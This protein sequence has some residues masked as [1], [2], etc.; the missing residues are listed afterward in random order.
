MGPDGEKEGVAFFLDKYLAAFPEKQRNALKK[1]AALHKKYRRKG[2][3]SADFTPESYVIHLVL[4]SLSWQKLLPP[5]PGEDVADAGSGGGYPGL[6]L[7][8]VRDD[9][10]ITLIEPAPRKAEYLR[11]AVATLGLRHV[12]VE[13]RQAEKVAAASFDCVGAKAVAR[14]GPVLKLAL[15][16]VRPGGRLVLFLGDVGAAALAKLDGQA[17]AAGGRLS[18]SGSYALPG[19]AKRRLLAEIIRE[20]DGVSRET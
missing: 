20:D 14:A 1:L 16:L 9:L 8:V 19:L 3:L 7:A 11:L 17:R 6:P 10:A 4:D 13:C 18:E 2:R 15:P 5:A 12:R